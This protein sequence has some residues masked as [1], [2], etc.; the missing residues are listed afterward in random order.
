MIVLF[1]NSLGKKNLH[2]LFCNF[3][4]GDPTHFLPQ[5]GTISFLEIEYEMLQV[6]YKIAFKEPKPMMVDSGV[7]F[8]RVR[9]RL[10]E[11]RWLYGTY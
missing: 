1:E 2:H 10:K 3:S 11:L 8:Y 9:V 7:D 5:E 4:Y 6:F